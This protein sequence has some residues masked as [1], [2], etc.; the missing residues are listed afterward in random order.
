MHSALRRVL[1]ALVLLPVLLALLVTGCGSTITI[2]L[3]GGGGAPGA[4]S[5][6]AAPRAPALPKGYT[7]LY[8]PAPHA[9]RYSALGEPV[10]RGRL[11]ER[12]EL[13]EGD[14]GGSDCGNARARAE[15]VQDRALTTA[16]LDRDI[17]YGW[18]FYN[19]SI[20]PVTRETS[21]GTV[22][23]QW[24]L[25]GDQPSIFRLVQ[26]AKGEGDMPRCDPRVCTPGGAATDDV[27][28]ELDEMA[29]ARGW[30]AAQNGGRICRL[31]SLEANRG[32]W[33]DI[34][35]NTNFGTDSYGYL[36]VWVNGELRC[37][38]QGQLVS[39]RA[40][41]G[42]SPGP[43]D[44]RGIFTSYTERW[45]KAFG[46]RPKP[47]LIAYWDEFRSGPSRADVDPRLREAQGLPPAD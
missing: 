10:R 29:Q 9:F 24:R 21:L 6:A 16:R 38:Y 15:I 30:G 42:Q 26:V 20:A 32:R 36:R 27:M 13:R 35:V 25:E 18:S 22:L 45:T 17:W 37:N 2:T 28:L 23:G 40:A 33:V 14:C 5:G 12:F 4:A 34:V 8:S 7:R 39:A 31:F 41:R 44:R 43:T 11:S 47:T 3:P 1:S 19:A 46:A